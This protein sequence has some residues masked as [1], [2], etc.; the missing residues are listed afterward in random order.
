MKTLNTSNGIWLGLKTTLLVFFLALQ[1]SSAQTVYKIDGGKSATL[2]VLG[3]SNV[4]D[5]T[6][7][8][9]AAESQGAFKFNAKDELIGLSTF[10]LT[11]AAKSLK[12][13]KSSMDSRTYKSLKADEFPT[14]SYQLKSVEITTI[15]ANKFKIQTKGTVAIAGKT[16]PITMM[17]TA[18]VNADKSITCTGSTA[19]KLTDF[20]IEPPSFMLGAMKVGNDLTVKFNLDYTKATATK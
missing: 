6:M 16:E 12:S 3:T 5:W 8:S 2:T 19:L 18:V 20:G 11:V 4:H 15:Q 9:T 14:I 7:V 10:N 17:V 13:G 1:T